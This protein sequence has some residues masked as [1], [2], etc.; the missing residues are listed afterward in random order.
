MGP[1]LNLSWTRKYL[2]RMYVDKA[3]VKRYGA[4][5]AEDGTVDMQVAEEVGEYACRVSFSQQ[6]QSNNSQEDI[7]PKII[8]VKLF[9]D[10]GVDIH[11]GDV[12]KA[13]KMAENGEVLQVIEGNAAEPSRYVNHIEVNL[14]ETGAA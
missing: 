4:V 2:N 6:D 7:S 3:Y 11:K 13:V 10:I 1:G 9:F 12:I 14:E 8:G 5:E